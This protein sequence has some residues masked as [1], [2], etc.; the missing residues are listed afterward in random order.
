MSNDTVQR[1]EENIRNAQEI[2]ALN[3]AL[4][5]L[6]ETRDFRTLIKSGYLEKESIRLVHL[7]ADPAF[8]TKERQ[9]NIQAQINGIG[10]LLQYFRTVK[11]NASIAKKAI[12][13]DEAMRDEILAEELQK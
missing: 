2:V 1:I 3:E 4:E 7:L 9:E 8:Q 6:T 10:Q 11:H 5:R 12:E 13:S